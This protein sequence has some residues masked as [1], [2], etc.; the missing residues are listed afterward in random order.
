MDKKIV[1]AFKD[2]WARYNSTVIL[3]DI[4]LTIQ[5]KEIISI[6]GPNGG[7]K[8]TLLR[9]IMGF[10]KPYR[11]NVSV[12]GIHPVKLK[13]MGRIGYLPQDVHHDFHFPLSVFDVVAMSRY[14]GKVFLERLSKNDR[15]CIHEA[16]KKVDM[17]DYKKH[18]FGSLSGGQ[19]QRT[20]IARALA[21]Q[22]EILLLDEPATG[23]DTVAQDSF[24]HLL[25]HLRDSENLTIIM[26]SHDIGS[27]SLVVDKIACLNKRI[28]FHGSPSSCFSSQ[29]K[30][31]KTFG[32]N[33][34]FLLHDQNCETCLRKK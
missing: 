8:T 4:N 15:E 25:S 27:V 29:E 33:I 13:N 19:R 16:L 20:L 3:E 32:T 17:A 6:V 18:H 22:P 26:V 28:H 5:K 24:Y 1:V 34:Q 7:G 21:L 9:I 31:Q 23:L 2:I 11:G 30:L 10:L 12:L 14:A